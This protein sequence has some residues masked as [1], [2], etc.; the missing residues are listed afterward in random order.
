MCKTVVRSALPF[1]F[2]FFFFW[3]GISAIVKY[4]YMTVTMAARQSDP[5]ADGCLWVG[6]GKQIISDGDRS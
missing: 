6:A 3:H 1:F 5:T 2:F 4:V